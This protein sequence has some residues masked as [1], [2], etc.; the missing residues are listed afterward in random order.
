MKVSVAVR[1]FAWASGLMAALIAWTP[2]AQ[3][4]VK[5]IVVDTKVSPAFDGQVYGNAG[6]YETL[7]GRAFGELDPNDPHNRIITDIQLAPRNANGMVEYI[8]SF[9]VVKPIDMSKSSHL[10]WHRVPNRG[11]RITIGE[12]ER[13]AGDIG[14]SSGWQGDS[15]GRT[16][17]GDDNDY[18]IVPAARNADG[19]PV[20]GPVL[21]RIVNA[22]GPDS[23][24]MRVNA[25]PVPYGPASLDTTQATLMTHAS[26]A[27]DGTIGGAR[28]IPSGDW[29]WARCSAANPFPG[30]PDP[31][32]ICLR[33]GFDPTL[34][35]E[36]V[37][38]A[39]DP[40]VL[41]IGFAA[42]R[43]VASF[44]K[45]STA[46][47]EGTPN[48]L[49][50]QVTAVIS[51]GQSQAGNFL[52]GFLH[53]G[54]NQDEAGRQVYDG[55]WPF[56]AGRRIS[57]NTRFA[58]PDGA[59]KLYE[60]GS[61][62]PQW[63][64]SWEDTVRGLPAAGILDRCTAS[65]SCPKVIE[66]FG[67]AEAWGLMISPGWVGTTAVADIPLPAN[68]RRYYIPSTPHGGGRGGF[69]VMPANAPNCPGPDFGRAMFAANPVSHDETVNALREHFRNW[70]M[71]DTLP[72]PSSFPTIADGFLV[73]PTKAAMGFPSIPGVPG[74]APTGL[75]NPMLHYD[76]GATFNHLDGSGVPSNVPPVV[77][78][79]IKMKVPRVDADGNELGG[80]PTVLR[81]APLGTYLGWNV[82]ADGFH[83]GKLCNYAGGMI[84]FA[85]TQA[86]RMASGDP[87]L[88]LEERYRNHDGYVAAVR[89]AAARA[90]AAKF[91]LQE[92]ADALI[93]EAAASDV[94]QPVQTTASSAGQ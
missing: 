28:A 25:N 38:T 93:A 48:P 56:V 35:Y 76:W 9:F 82:V 85:E 27:M 49:A 72:P 83:K 33:S 36:V 19:S 37:F 52:R 46:D 67:A 57:L 1:R 88:S 70:V 73:D 6:Q 3:A 13:R 74:D 54:F 51:Q 10:M 60:A 90:V 53:L 47:A 50:N 11:G 8:A 86:Q 23:S 78:G 71:H 24:P 80:V 58:Q 84:P 66:H 17:P 26:E 29:A 2:T 4:E 21:G 20:T 16:V 69:S 81:D 18:A 39:Q 30:T 77:R 89:A 14:L 42:F 15:S 65:N 12:I 45:Y 87:R 44:L 43:D 5:K 91:L 40:P 64:A 31:T 41:G 92:D 55:L 61:E 34:L 22:S 68:V 32:Q 62:G 63:W 75:V 79:V 94:L 7:A 59:L